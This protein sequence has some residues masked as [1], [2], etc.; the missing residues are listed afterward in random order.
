MSYIDVR[1]YLQQWRLAIRSQRA[2]CNL[3]NSVDCLG[4][5]MG[6]LWS[7][8]QLDI[9]H[10]WYWKLRLVTRDVVNVQS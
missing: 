8:I 4:I 2:T 6:I 7:K 9:T 1:C 10:S 5:S 3:G